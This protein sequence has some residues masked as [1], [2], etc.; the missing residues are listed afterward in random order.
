MSASADAYSNPFAIDGLT[1]P[2]MRSAYAILGIEAEDLESTKLD[3]VLAR[4]REQLR[5]DPDLASVYGESIS[6]ADLEAAAERLADPKNRVINRLLDHEYHRFDLAELGALDATIAAYRQQ[7][8]DR[9]RPSLHGLR[10]IAQLLLDA[11]GELHPP[12][13]DGLQG[14]SPELPAG[15]E[16]LDSLL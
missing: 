15:S 4:A 2:P 12:Q 13:V 7:L 14:D 3:D 8:L 5:R 10:L 1:S 6:E 9:D 11:A 16:I